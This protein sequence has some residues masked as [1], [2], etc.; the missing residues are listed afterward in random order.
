[1]TVSDLTPQLRQQFGVRRNMDG[2]LITDVDADSTAYAEGLRPGHII[3]QIEHEPVSSAQDVMDIASKL[4]G[5][6]VL[7]HVWTRSGA[8]F[9]VIPIS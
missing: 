9:V 1:M 3:L 2:A 5:E 6:T 7:L 8:R 4:K